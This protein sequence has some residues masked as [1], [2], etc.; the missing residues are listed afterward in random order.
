ME[1]AEQYGYEHAQKEM[2]RQRIIMLANDLR[3]TGTDGFVGFW[4]MSKFDYNHDRSTTEDT[5][6][7]MSTNDDSDPVKRALMNM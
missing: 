4:D 7:G 2:E 3:A 1:K 5:Y 6:N